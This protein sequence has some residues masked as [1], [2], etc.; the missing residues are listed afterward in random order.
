MRRL[1]WDG[2][3]S[4][5]IN[6]LATTP[7][8][9]D[10]RTIFSGGRSIKVLRS[11]EALSNKDR[12]EECRRF[13]SQAFQAHTNAFSALLSG[14]KDPSAREGQPSIRCTQWALCAAMFATADAGRRDLLSGQFAQLDRFK[15]DFQPRWSAL[16][17]EDPQ[18]GLFSLAT[19]LPDCR[20]Q[21]NLL[22]L[23]AARSVAGDS[24]LDQVDA[25]CGLARMRTYPIPVR[26]W[27]SRATRLENLQIAAPFLPARGWSDFVVYDWTDPLVTQEQEEGLVLT[28][29]QI[30]LH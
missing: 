13:F 4:S 25:E 29:R 2:P 26:D 11:F 1:I 5:F 12:E 9:T 21:V 18:M 14:V 28:L 23:A 6:G 30:V 3:E 16:V 27:D 15:A 7:G 19:Y 20:F 22:R 17:A 10:L 8:E 24:R